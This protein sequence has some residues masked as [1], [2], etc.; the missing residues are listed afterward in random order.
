[1]RSRRDHACVSPLGKRK[2]RVRIT[3]THSQD[4]WRKCG[5][6]AAIITH[7]RSRES[8]WWSQRGREINVN[9][10]EDDTVFL[11][12]A[13]ERE[14][15]VSAENA[16]REARSELDCSMGYARLVRLPLSFS[17]FRR[18]RFLLRPA[19]GPTIW[20]DLTVCLASG[21]DRHKW[22]TRCLLMYI[23]PRFGGG[24]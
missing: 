8:T 7:W 21:L 20:A 10:P 23:V 9:H 19:G 14:W 5:G 4:R 1:M 3:V 24:K 16:Q 22:A 2:S 15:S 6:S 11:Q 13:L 18:A 12:V 17:F